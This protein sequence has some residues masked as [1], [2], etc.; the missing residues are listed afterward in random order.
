MFIEQNKTFLKPLQVLE[1]KNKR[2]KNSVHS[3]QPNKR[4]QTLCTAYSVYENLKKISGLIMD[5][6]R[7]IRKRTSVGS[8]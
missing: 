1:A 8:V 4:F 2:A 5:L 7:K 6:I 3:F